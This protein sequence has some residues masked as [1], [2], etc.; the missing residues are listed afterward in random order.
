M[1]KVGLITVASLSNGRSPNVPARQPHMPSDH[2]VCPHPLGYSGNICV[3]TNSAVR[4][5]GSHRFDSLFTRQKYEER[6]PR[7]PPQAVDRVLHC[8]NRVSAST[9][10]SFPISLSQSR[11]K[12]NC[13]NTTITLSIVGN[14][15]D[16]HTDMF[17]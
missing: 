4:I 11:L 7:K 15:C 5:T 6:E 17:V 12:R 9:Q 10:S 14:L 2:P 8:Q 13:G 1:A 3:A 16:R